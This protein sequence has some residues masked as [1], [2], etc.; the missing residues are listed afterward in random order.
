MRH[1]IGFANF[2]NT[3]RRLHGLLASSGRRRMSLPLRP[4]PNGRFFTSVFISNLKKNQSRDKC[5]HHMFHPFHIKLQSF[6]STLVLLR[7]TFRQLPRSHLPVQTERI[8]IQFHGPNFCLVQVIRVSL[9]PS[10][11]RQ[12]SAQSQIN[13]NEHEKDHWTDS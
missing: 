8:L 13:C 5:T 6:A 9:C 10:S 7:K 2:C 12:E 1:L 4:L 3:N 11:H